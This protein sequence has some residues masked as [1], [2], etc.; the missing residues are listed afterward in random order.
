MKLG[1]AT[2]R[3]GGEEFGVTDVE[4]SVL[5]PLRASSRFAGMDV[6][7]RMTL[8]FTARW[9]PVRSNP[10]RRAA[11]RKDLVRL[12]GD[13]RIDRTGAVVRRALREAIFAG[14]RI[15]RS[16]QRFVCLESYTTRPLAAT[17]RGT[18]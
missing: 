11:A 8:S 7:E 4:Y 16:L 1:R 15:P 5:D 17:N 10:K 3:I 6:P 12:A 9:V 13:A 2:V 18:K 14:A